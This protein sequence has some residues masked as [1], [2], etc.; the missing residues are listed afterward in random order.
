MKIIGLSSSPR[1][2]KSLTARLV[3]AVLEG[4]GKAGAEIEFVDLCALHLEFCQ[5]CGNCYSTG[6]C[7]HNDDFKSLYA[8]LIAS[9]GLVLGSPDYLSSISAQ[10]K[11]LLDRMSDAIHC[12]ALS[13]KYGCAVASSGGPNHA[14]VTTYINQLLITFGANV[15]GAVGAAASIPGQMEKAVIEARELGRT[16]VAA[17]REKRVHPEQEAAHAQIRARFKSL[18][19]MNK[20]LWPHEYEHWQKQG[21]L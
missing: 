19:T 18:V 9:D 6:T 2:E 15:A 4:A 1:G 11:V 17:I 14:E 5:A 12:Q 3:K 16:L 20:A 10:M 21:W 8:K 13:G 7:V